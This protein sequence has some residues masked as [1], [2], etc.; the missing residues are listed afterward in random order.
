M[1]TIHNSDIRFELNPRII[2]VSDFEMTFYT[3][4]KRDFS[5]RKTSADVQEV[6]V[7]GET[8]YYLDL[9]WSLL[10]YVGKGVLNY[11][12][13]N[14][15]TDPSF[16]D[17]EY[18]QLVEKATDYYIDTFKV[19]PESTDKSITELL[20]EE[21]EARIAGDL[22]LS[23]A[24]TTEVN[25]RI[26]AD[27]AISGAV[28]TALS[29]KQDTLIAGDN[30]SISGNVISATGGDM[31]NYYT[32][33]EVDSALSG[34]ADSD[35]V[36]LKSETSG[37]TEISTALD[38]KLDVTAYTPTDLSNYY[39]KSETSGKTEISTALATKLD[40]TAYTPTDL[41]NY[42]TKSETSGKTEISTAL[43]A[44]AD[45][46][47]VYTKSET[48][49]KTEISTALA[50]K[51]D[52][53]AYTP[54]DL[55]NYYKKSETS[56]K[57][58]ISTAF[59]SISGAVDT[60]LLGY[61]NN[62][63]YNTSAK[64]INLLHGNTVIASID[65][66]DFIK[67]GMVDNVVISGGSLVIT[68][69]TDSGKEAITIALTDIF[70]PSNYYT[71]SD[72]DS[73]LSGKAD[74]TAV[75]EAINQ[76]VSGKADSSNVYTKSETSGATEISTALSGKLDTTAY[77][78]T[79]L[80]NYYTKGETSGATEISTALSAKLD[81][82]AYTP[83]D[84]SNY[85]TKGET[86]GATEISTALSG[87]QETLVSGTN[88]KTINNESILGS[89]NITIEGG[90]SSINVVQTTGTSSGDVM[91][92][93]AVTTALSGKLDTTAY[94]PTDLSNYYT[95]SETSGKTEI[96]TALST[97]LDTTA[98]TPTDL[99]NYYTKSE[100]S[101]KTEI[102]TALAAKQGTLTAGTGI[103]ITNDVISVTGGTGGKA[104]EAGRGIS[105]TTGETADTVSFNLP[106]S[107][108]TG[109][110]SIVEGDAR[111][112][113]SGISSHAEGY[114]T[115]SMRIGDHAEGYYTYA[116]GDNYAAH[117]EGY[118]TSAMTSSCHAEGRGTKA[119][120]DCAHA[121][122]IST[123]AIGKNSHAEGNDTKASG[124]SSHAEGS[125]T[126]ASN[127]SK[128]SGIAAYAGYQARHA[129][130]C[131]TLANNGSTH[132]EGYFTLANNFG[133]HASG[134]YNISS[135][136][137][138]TFGD[139]GNTLFSVG[140]GTD[141]N[142]RHNAF[143]IRQN[144]DIYITSGGTD[145]K[146]QD[147]LGG[148][149]SSVTVVQTTGTSTTDVMSQDAV[150]TA[151][152]SK[153]GTLSAGTGVDITND[154]I[155]VTGGGG[156]SVTVVQTTGTSTTDV[157]SQN[158]VTTA[159]AS[160]QDT[161]VSGTNIKSI[162]GNSILGSGNIDIEGGNN[163][164]E[165]TQAQYNAL[166]T[167]DPDT[168]YI[169]TDA[170]PADLSNYYTKSE[171][172]GKTE[173]STAFAAKQDTLTAG[174]GIAITSNVISV[175]GSTGG[176]AVSGGTNISITTGETADTI[177]CTLP[178]TAGTNSSEKGIIVGDSECSSTG[179]Y[180]IAVGH[181]ADAIGNYSF[182]MGSNSS[183][184]GQQSMRF[185][186]SKAAN[187]DHSIALGYSCE[188]DKTSQVAI[189][190]D[191]KPINIY[192]ISVGVCNK[193]VS[194]STTFG[195]SGNTLFSVGNGTSTS[196]RHNAFE[197]RQNGDIYITS[198]GTDIKLQDNLGGGGSSINVVQTTGTSTGDVM[199]Q[200][201]VT[202][203]LS[204]K[205]DA[206]DLGGLKLQ[207]VTQAQYDAITNKDASTLYV[208]VN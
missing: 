69:N 43:S 25:A 8:K 33:S 142:A 167:K 143:E 52:T 61:V 208:I 204:G 123:I 3:V 156:S 15:I 5:F 105:I 113:A 10:S 176:K 16:P 76:A 67:D 126:I 14:N 90:G 30:I 73:A 102:S 48:S 131:S 21:V 134:V 130:G 65:A 141:D 191:L 87:K 121:E 41:S 95:K 139:S 82:T 154:V 157:M 163:V 205:A 12:C 189:G 185:G 35:D 28:D 177:N 64:A 128:V 99:T 7:S 9:D 190:R 24:V 109:T 164:V 47:D 81:T 19:E 200:D 179:K 129:E 74:T 106:I 187:G 182:A 26:A 158:A 169:I 153:Q 150:T 147:N 57:T 88:I 66:T 23:G 161:L 198:G 201:A 50:S 63:N 27:E 40:T 49:G 104:I 77:T 51:L 70:D 178:I 2:Y 36:Y 116:N 46:S 196:A 37:K 165:L 138:T 59:T 203:A 32:K 85:Y 78:P 145:I 122:G 31:S 94:T 124:Y 112:I 125:Y 151:L 45:S 84:L 146:L 54:T 149:G 96:S 11:Q 93:N 202:T 207:Q 120:G 17:G 194:A 42:Y 80:S 83:T 170:T 6:E 39:T 72:V 132:V 172:S 181:N 115:I 103:D 62:A 183:A 92:Q 162:N 117:A 168:F 56:G 140:N 4:N 114:Q 160:K 18:N 86:S 98:Y 60:A 111:N 108:G 119:S 38:G 193:S 44:K 192:E 89:G 55:S 136:A 137:S 118:K 22:A 206:A 100:T 97:K 175:T 127:V 68:F 144:G 13:I 135:S 20:G 71:K 174:T 188:T 159:L 133:E 1:K 29:G 152:A 101:G 199:S 155:S 184:R 75:T 197:I 53:T 171:T 58:E 166:T 148:G 107:A 180:S 79:D 91:S 34:K 173:L 110:N 195:D 186:N